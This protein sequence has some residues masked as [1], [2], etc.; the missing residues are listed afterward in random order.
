MQSIRK[1]LSITQEEEISKARYQLTKLHQESNQLK[2]ANDLLERK[3]SE[4]QGRLVALKVDES[5][6]A[7]KSVNTSIQ[8]K[9]LS[10][11]LN[12]INE[13]IATELESKKVIQLMAK[14]LEKETS[15]CK[16]LHTDLEASVSTAR[17]ENA[18]LHKT[19]LFCYREL[20]VEEKRLKD[21]KST[22]KDRMHQRLDKMLEL[23]SIVSE[24]EKNRLSA[25][26]SVIELQRSV[27][28][29]RKSQTFD[30]FANKSE[31]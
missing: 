2:I 6:V 4:L 21:L 27:E 12:D 3:L 25:H 15:N 31:R 7:S 29:E 30:L 11:Q 8:E 5:R 28:L 9:A 26:E 23:R 19:I 16:L 17:T 1:E 14:R 24:G 10:A 20:G 18:G 22:L 13:V